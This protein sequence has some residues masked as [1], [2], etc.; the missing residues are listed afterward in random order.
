MNSSLKNLPIF[1]F[2]PCRIIEVDTKLYY[3]WPVTDEIKTRIRNILDDQS[4]EFHFDH[5]IES[6]PPYA[7]P[8]CGVDITLFDTVREAVEKSSHAKEFLAKALQQEKIEGA[9]VIHRI[10]CE[11]GHPQL[12]PMGWPDTFDWILDSRE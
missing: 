3:L 5:T 11:N 6:M 1:N 8:E 7:C 2:K 12:M 9:G 4:M 10:K